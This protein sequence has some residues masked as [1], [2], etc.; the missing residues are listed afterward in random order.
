MHNGII[1]NHESLR[2]QLSDE[3]YEF[4]GQTD[5]EV[6]AHLIHS[7]YRGDLLAAVRDA[8]SQLHGAYAIAVFSKSEP[9]RLDLA[10]SVT[11]E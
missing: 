5:T 10:K 8:T 6:V 4:D 7:V 3:H 1:E 2:S 11:V 9:R